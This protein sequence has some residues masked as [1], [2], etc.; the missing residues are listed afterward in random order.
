MYPWV[1]PSWAWPASCWTSLREPP[2]STILR[3][4]RVMKVRRPL[5]LEQPARP[6]PEYRR[7]N[8]TA[9]EAAERPVPRSDGHRNRPYKPDRFWFTMLV[10][11]FRGGGRG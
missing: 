8:H 9:T 4:A 1:V 10:R 5:W 2:A 11:F 6:M 3:A 7:W